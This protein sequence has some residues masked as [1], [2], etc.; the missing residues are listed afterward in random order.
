M[1]QREDIERG[2]RTP[3]LG[4]KAAEGTRS[5]SHPQQPVYLGIGYLKVLF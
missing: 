5:D 1:L 4:I 2:R 3:W